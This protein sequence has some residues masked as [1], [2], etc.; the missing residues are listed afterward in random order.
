MALTW[1]RA[2]SWRLGRQLL[3][4]VGAAG[5]SVV[6][7]VGRLGSVP[8]WPATAAEHG[9]AARRAGGRVGDVAEAFAAGEVVTVYAFGGATHVMTPQDA[10]AYLAVRA[11]SRMW[12]L[13]SWVVHYGLAPDDWPA[14]RRYVRDA[15]AD[16]PLTRSELLDA[17]ARSRRYRHLRPLLADGNDTLLKPLSWHGDIGFAPGRDGEAAYQRLDAVPGWAGVPDAD[18]GAARVLDHYLRVHGPAPLERAGAWLGQGLGAR[19]RD[20]VRWLA[21]LEPRV[22]RLDVEGVEV[23]VLAEDVDDLRAA[24]AA[25]AGSSVAL[26]PGRDPWVTAPGTDDPRVVPPAHRSAISRN[27]NP[28]LHR[29]VV[30]GTWTLKGEALRV[31]WFEGS[32]RVPRSGLDEAAAR[33]G[34]A[35]GREVGV[36]VQGA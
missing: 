34:A 31:T 14:F 22:V 30:A 23:A 8:A 3:D 24:R 4:P 32:G 33:L 26:L 11:S 20:V 2:L 21:A 7:V 25:P 13:R 9:V 15:L 29:G 36:D 6:D 5:T 18:A 10:G 12:A 1:A 27:G 28:V 35:V 19:R 17:F 16:G